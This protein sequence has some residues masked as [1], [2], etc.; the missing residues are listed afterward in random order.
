LAGETESGRLSESKMR[1]VVLSI[2]TGSKKDLAG[3]GMID[4]ETGRK[5]LDLTKRNF[6]LVNELNLAN[7][8]NGDLVGQLSRRKVT[9]EKLQSEFDFYK[10]S[11]Q[12]SQINL[13]TLEVSQDEILEPTK[14]DL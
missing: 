1:G 11:H 2:L 7:K 13:H 8:D 9:I 10:S 3:T 6:L 5:V 14:T 4:D 12:V